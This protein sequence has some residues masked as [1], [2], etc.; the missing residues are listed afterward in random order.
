MTKEELKNKFVKGR[1][2]VVSEQ[3]AEAAFE[4]WYENYIIPLAQIYSLAK[5]RPIID[6]EGEEE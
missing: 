5:R 6:K 3:D 2:P 4:D 1:P